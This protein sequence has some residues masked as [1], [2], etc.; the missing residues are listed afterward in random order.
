[1]IS[2]YTKDSTDTK[3]LDVERSIGLRLLRF[4]EEI[5]ADTYTEISDADYL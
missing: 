1:M 5:D 3:I 4:N 2:E